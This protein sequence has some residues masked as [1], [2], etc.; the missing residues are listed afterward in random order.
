MIEDGAVFVDG[1]RV[2]VCSRAAPIGARIDLA[3]AEG[4]PRPNTPPGLVFLDEHLAVADKP[5]GVPTE[6]TREGSRGTLL[7][8]LGDTLRERGEQ[9]QFLHA[10]HRLDADTTG[11]VAF[12]RSPAAAAAL[13]KQ[14]Q[15]GTVDRRYLALVN[16]VPGWAEARLDQPLARHRDTNGR[17][18]VDPHG[19]ASVTHVRVLATGSGAALLVCVPATGRTHQLRVHLADAGHALVGDR[20]Y[21][22]TRGQE[23]HLG[24]HAVLLGLVHPQGQRIDFVAPPPES[25][26]ASAES[27]GLAREVVARLVSEVIQE[28]APLWTA[29]G[30]R[31]TA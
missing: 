25:F 8:S 1:K 6:P 7:A 19:L 4:P 3:I 10:A 26:L 23:G 20:R 30:A 9:T 16:G 18:R 21:G 28:P 14:L 15:A 13:G 22:E 17:I 11:V 31:E 24:L 29:A 12:A 2:Q 27:R 5:G